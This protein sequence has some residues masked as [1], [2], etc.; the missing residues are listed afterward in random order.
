[1]SK[2][3]K[4]GLSK[5][6]R[7]LWQR[8]ARTATPM[9]RNRPVLPQAPT[10][11]ATPEIKPVDQSVSFVSPF[12]VSPFKIGQNAT[13]SAALT[14]PKP[15]GSPVDRKK[16]AKLRRGKLKPEAR[17]DLHGMTQEQ[18]LPALNSFVQR[19]SERKLRLV[20]VIT[21]KGRPRPDYGPI[22]EQPGVLRRNVPHW[23]RSRLLA[24][25]VLDVV[26]SHQ[27]HGGSG[28]FY[29]YLRARR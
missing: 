25:L 23:L 6:D 10:E 1:M 3:N 15:T 29:V 14:Q 7:E 21:G 27:S 19:A 20:L 9:H 28:A 18:A 4:R 26:E 16:L 13:S 2:R 11:R 8:V 5:E 24:P 17:I 12:K 22:P